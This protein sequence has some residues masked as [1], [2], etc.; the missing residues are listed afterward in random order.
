MP[1]NPGSLFAQEVT[2][3]FGI[4][5]A[6]WR[7]IL[8]ASQRD[9][10]DALAIG[11]FRTGL[12]LYVQANTPRLQ[13]LTSVIDTAPATPGAGV[14][15]LCGLLNVAAATQDFDI[16]FVN[17]DP[18]AGAVG[19]HLLIYASRPQAPSINFFKGPY[20]LAGMVNGAVVLPTSPVTVAAPFPIVAGQK[21]FVQV[22]STDP[23]GRLS[24]IQRF[25]D[26]VA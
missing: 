5:V 13:A 3:A 25:G 23:D 24:A 8:S 2:A 15:S 14:L 10:W 9:A 1:V 20:R 11:T 6:R 16:N 7:T 26:L 17:T 12:N 4:L 21:L 18:W 22:R 19:G